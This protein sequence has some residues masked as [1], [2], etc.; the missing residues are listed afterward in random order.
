[1]FARLAG[2]ATLAAAFHAVRAR[3]GGPGGDGE[4]IHSFAQNLTPRLARLSEDLLHG[5]YRPGPLRHV[6]IPKK[7]GGTRTLSIPC[8]VDR[9]AQ[10]AAKDVL[11]PLLE[12]TFEDASYAYRAGCGVQTAVAR[13]AALRRE[14]YTFVVDGD[15]RAFF[16]NIPHRLL[17]DKLAAVIPDSR[18]IGLVG[19][20]LAGFSPDG[21]GLAQGSP[22]SPLLANLFLDALDEKFIKGPVRIVRFAD[23]FVL[24]AKSRGAAEHALADAEALLTAHGLTMNRAK[25]RIVPFDGA[26]SFLGYLFVRSLTLQE[27][28]A[29]ELPDDG[30]P[31]VAGRALGPAA[32]PPAAD[33][34]APPVPA[35]APPQPVVLVAP[36]APPPPAPA[37]K[38]R[39]TLRSDPAVLEYLEGDLDGADLATGRAPLYVLEAGRRLE[40]R[41]EG[42][43]VTENGRELV[44]LPAHLVQRID[45]GPE[46]EAN[47]AALRLAAAHG[48]PVA[49]LDGRGQPAAILAPRQLDD[50]RLHL[51]Q[52]RLV[53]EPARA[54]ALVR[55]LVAGR[56][57]NARVLLI[58]LNRRRD[59]ASVRT[60]TAAMARLIERARFAAVDADAARG[61]EGAAA[62]L[63][64]PALGALLQHGFAL[65]R[66]REDPAN[67]VTAILNWT[68]SLLGR[69]VRAAVLRAG[70]HPGFGALHAAGDDR[71]ACVYDLME[72]FRAPLAEGLTVYLFNNRILQPDDFLS[73][74]DHVHV[75]AEARKRVIRHWEAWLAR[76]IRLPETGRRTTWRGLV[77]AQARALARAAQDGGGYRP[78]AMDH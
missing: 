39:A 42:F 15:I 68:A 76:P 19:Q 7:T 46:V 33:E 54:L 64:W 52:A 50:A 63:Y 71:E 78:Y 47:D 4:T 30:F 20:W 67:P 74:P 28:K 72:E 48:I 75:V 21:K 32:M 44:V 18:V 3:G 73:A 60:A 27:Q 35:D 45:L 17:L 26:L 29:A 13:V 69:E 65:P 22:L 11:E 61:V 31:L 53:L 56:V 36:P 70:L 40:V 37:A 6:A 5:L 41:G 77:L 10:R 34:I 14:G 38:P 49:L 59:R 9:V 62:R 1:M 8:V 25:T 66:R 16:D 55:T 43:G 12:P 58:R 23:D 24:L 57:V 2:I 51:A